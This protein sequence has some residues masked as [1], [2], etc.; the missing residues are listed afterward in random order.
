MAK[1]SQR[2]LVA[3]VGGDS[4]LARELRE[5]LDGVAPAPR[6]QLISASAKPSNVLSIADE[7]AAVLAPLNA[8]SLEGAAV[9]FLAGTAASS[10]RALKINPEKGPHL[11]DLTGTLDELPAAKLR[12]PSAELPSAEHPVSVL[13]VIAHPAAVALT[14]LL[15]RLAAVAPVRRCVAH[16]FE[17]A[18]ERGQGGIEELRKQTVGVLSFKKLDTEVFDTQLAFNL[19][20]RFGEEALEPLEEVEQRV[21]RHTASLLSAWPNL[22][23]PSVRLIQ[24]PVFHGHSISM[25][26]E[27]DENPGAKVLTAKLTEAGVDVRPDEPPSNAQIAGQ[28]GLS[29]GA[30]LADRNN[31]RAC[32]I[33]M[34]AD[35]LRLTAENAVAVAKERL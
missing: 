21:E 24:A 16:I 10:R 5:L 3:V 28:S 29:V 13:D 2:P 6:V 31:P 11:I 15:T 7:D 18:S 25:W 23:M 35:N 33:W 34:V 17:P 19:L 14:M 9:A 20:S 27:F 12:A 8:E 4:L 22:P 26:V 30:I 1:T 32:W